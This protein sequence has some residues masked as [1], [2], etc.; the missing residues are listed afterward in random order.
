M[1]LKILAMFVLMTLTLSCKSYLQLI[2]TRTTNTKIID[3]KY[4]FENDS[5]KITYDFWKEKGLL[6]FTVYNKL[7]KPLYIDWKKS[8]YINNT[9][10][11][12]YWED[13]ENTKTVGVQNSSTYRIGRTLSGFTNT[14]SVSSSLTTK[15]EKLTFVPPNSN[16]TRQQFYLLPNSFLKIPEKNYTNE[17]VADINDPNNELT[18]FVKEF[19]KDNA[20]LIFRNF[21][22]FSYSDK[23][24]KEFY[25]DNEFYISKVTK[26]EK[27]K[28]GT[29]KYDPKLGSSFYLRDENGQFQYESPYQKGTAFYVFMSSQ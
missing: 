17:K 8:S 26:M 29:Y 1:K 15:P 7:K 4:V 2:E 11:L 9:V 21:I 16:Y 19:A 20:P 23:F 28:F 12:N 24:E 5:I 6:S 14:S 3:N 18:V 25:L 13:E 22:T 27:R 10:K